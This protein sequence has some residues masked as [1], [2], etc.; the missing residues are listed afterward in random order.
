MYSW[1]G[2]MKAKSSAAIDVPITS[3]S[4]L[5]HFWELIGCH[6]IADTVAVISR[7]LGLLEL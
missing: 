7:I 3:A 2:R 6:F 5:L 4:T 1:M